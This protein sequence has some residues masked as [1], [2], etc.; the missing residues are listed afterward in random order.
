MFKQNP[1]AM[2]TTLVALLTAAD[3]TLE[4]LHVLSPSVAA[5]AAGAIAVLTAVLGVVTHGKVTPLVNPHDDLGRA[6]APVSPPPR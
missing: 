6:L 5:W 3:G 4:G 2:L 1:V